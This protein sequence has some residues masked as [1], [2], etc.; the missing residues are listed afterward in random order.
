[1]K[2]VPDVG[3]SRSKHEKTSSPGRKF[4]HERSGK[5]LGEGAGA[6]GRRFRSDGTNKQSRIGKDIICSKKAKWRGRK[7][8][9][10]R[11]HQIQRFGGQTA[12]VGRATKITTSGERGWENQSW[13]KILNRKVGETCKIRTAE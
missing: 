7:V 1:L 13:E 6:G 11:L 3:V 12:A 10:E 9:G 5:G 2:F 4:F 8:P